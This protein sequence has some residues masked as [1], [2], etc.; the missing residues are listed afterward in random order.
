MK[1]KPKRGFALLSRDKHRKIARLG[2]IASHMYGRGH[3]WTSEEARI[4]SRKGG[5]NRSEDVKINK[6]QA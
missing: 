5:R 2:G 4:A 6:R 3:E 1:T